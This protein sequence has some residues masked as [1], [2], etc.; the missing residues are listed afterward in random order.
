MSSSVHYLTISVQSNLYDCL[1]KD[2]AFRAILLSL[3]PYSADL[4][5]FFDA[6]SR[7]DAE[8]VKEIIEEVQET[9]GDMSSPKVDAFFCRASTCAR[10]L[11]RR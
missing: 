4:Y 3:L 8:E 1:Q 6:G 10:Q 2:F 11:S 9:I 7:I 5:Q